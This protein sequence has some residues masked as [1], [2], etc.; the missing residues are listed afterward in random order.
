MFRPIDYNALDREFRPGKPLSTV[1]RRLIVDLYLSVEGPREISP[2]VRVTYNGVCRIHRGPTQSVCV[3]DCYFIVNVLDL[4]F[5]SPV[6]IY[7]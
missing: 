6:A 7:R 2:T 5:A 1:I 4:P 3:A